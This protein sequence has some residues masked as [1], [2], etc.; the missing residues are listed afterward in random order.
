[1]NLKFKFIISLIITV[2]LFQDWI[3]NYKNEVKEN[4]LFITPLT[5]PQ[6]ELI[7]NTLY[8]IDKL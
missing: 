5:L 6:N 2:L 3:T 1:M 7:K 8:L 4:V